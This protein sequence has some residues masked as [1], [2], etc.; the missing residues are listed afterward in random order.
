MRYLVVLDARSVVGGIYA[1]GH[2]DGFVNDGG[3]RHPVLD[4]TEIATDN[5][6]YLYVKRDLSLHGKDYQ[7]INIPHSSVSVIHH[8]ADEGSKP[9]GFVSAGGSAP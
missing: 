3:I 6:Y 7:F 1:N 2:N 4:C 5:P 9:I 8:Y